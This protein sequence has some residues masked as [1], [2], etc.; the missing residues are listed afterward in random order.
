MQ[1]ALSQTTT[2]K[3]TIV[4]NEQRMLIALRKE[5]EIIVSE[6]VKV[7]NHGVHNLS[8]ICTLTQIAPLLSLATLFMHAALVCI[9]RS[10]N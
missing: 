5:N 6:L 10:V 9:C 3:T 8:M 2:I 1:E 7:H 4:E